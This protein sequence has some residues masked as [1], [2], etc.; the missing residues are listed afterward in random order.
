MIRIGTPYTLNID[1]KKVS[2][3]FKKEWSRPIALGDFNFYKWQFIEV[4]NQNNIDNCCIAINENSDVIGVMGV[5]SREFIDDNT[6]VNGGELTTWIVKPEYRNKGIGPKMI[7]FLIDKYDILIGMGISTDALP[8]YLRSGF[9]YL[10][11]IPRY[12]K[13]IDWDKYKRELSHRK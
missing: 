1:S 9:K 12:I 5:N 8:V 2:S 11:S 7:N 4:P 3:F 6:C 10:K 13:V